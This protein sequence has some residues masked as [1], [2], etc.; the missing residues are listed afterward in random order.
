MFYVG[1]VLILLGFASLAAVGEAKLPP[2]PKA[3][4][5]LFA[6]SVIAILV[7]FLLPLAADFGWGEFFSKAPSKLWNTF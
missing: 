5:K 2:D 7:G 6:V 4:K 3:F 1:L